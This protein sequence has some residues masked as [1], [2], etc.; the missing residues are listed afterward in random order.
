MTFTI[1][2][3]RKLCDGVNSI[4]GIAETT[5]KA[6]ETLWRGVSDQL[7]EISRTQNQRANVLDE[8]ALS[9]G[10]CSRIQGLL[11][12]QEGEIARISAMLEGISQMLSIRLIS[13]DSKIEDIEMALPKKKES[14]NK[15][16]RVSKDTK[17]QLTA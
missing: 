17:E 4:K 5:L 13:I 16:D 2:D 9:V 12:S 3:S 10:V 15:K 1:E 14:N 11:Q 6:L 7:D 8:L